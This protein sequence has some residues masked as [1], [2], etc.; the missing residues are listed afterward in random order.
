MTLTEL[1]VA[2]ADSIRA[3][4]GT[5]ELINATDFPSEIESIEAGSGGG[6]D[7]PYIPIEYIR[8]T[9]TQY[10]N[11][12]VKVNGNLKTE[13][14]FLN[15]QQNQSTNFLLGGR[16]DAEK[17]TYCLMYNGSSKYIRTYDKKN[18]KQKITC[19]IEQLSEC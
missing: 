6:A 2:I 3:K 5:T 12:G 15:L 11:T 1:F 18:K 10:I 4:K 13:L 19:G 7:L 17:N 14:V 9:G 8:S 16:E